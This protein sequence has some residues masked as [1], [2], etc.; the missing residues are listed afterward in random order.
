MS[1]PSNQPMGSSL[2]R[3]FPP[4]SAQL[5]NTASSPAAP[6][7]PPAG[8]PTPPTPPPRPSSPFGARLGGN[9]MN[10]RIV[11]VVHE[12]VRFDLNGLGDPFHRL[13]GRPLQVEMGDP[14][15][16]V[17]VMESSG[18]DVNAI[19]QKLELAWESYDLNGAM[20][21]YT[22]RKD[23]RQMFAGRVPTAEESEEEEHFDDEKR[24]PPAVLR[25]VDLLLVLN[26][27]AR[28]R[29]RILLPTTPPAMQK[30]FLLQSLYSDDP[31]LVNLAKATGCFEETS[32]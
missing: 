15:K 11:P 13:L 19:V 2:L 24:N 1:Q 17:E 30:E 26:V 7:P 3:R 8:P 6:P 23:L 25:A 32:A 12:L 22:W 10:W 18:S 5:N 4:A 20:L 27:L 31:R 16:A 14:E 28:T 9:K 21:V 29:A